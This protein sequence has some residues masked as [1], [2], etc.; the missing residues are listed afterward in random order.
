[1]IRTILGITV[2]TA[3][4]GATLSACSSDID[5]KC[6][7]DLTAVYEKTSDYGPNAKAHAEETCKELR[8][9]QRVDERRQKNG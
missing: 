8:D 5:P 1:M 9:L 7:R 6:V 3:I 4:S 2:V